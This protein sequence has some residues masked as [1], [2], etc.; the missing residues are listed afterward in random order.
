VVL[1]NGFRVLKGIT[2]QGEG[3]PF[4][5]IPTRRI[6]DYAKYSVRSG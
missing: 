5:S 6:V 4:S 3:E 1:K 2:S